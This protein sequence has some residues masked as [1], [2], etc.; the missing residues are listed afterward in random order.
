M[1]RPPKKPQR[2]RT[3][4]FVTTGV[5]PFCKPCFQEMMVD[6]TSGLLD[7]LEQKNVPSSSQDQVIDNGGGASEDANSLFLCMASPE[8]KLAC[9]PS[10]GVD[11]Q[12]FAAH[13]VACLDG[14]TPVVVE[15]VGFGHRT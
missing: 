7:S 14:N 2:S 5:I 6:L 3:S 13:T 1:E 12:A 9:R 8:D 15:T 10:G 11:Q 4:P